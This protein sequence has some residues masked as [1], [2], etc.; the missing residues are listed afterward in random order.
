M[1]TRQ[2][3]PSH[4][5]NRKEKNPCP[6]RVTLGMSASGSAPG[7]FFSEVFRTSRGNGS[8]GVPV[9]PASIHGRTRSIGALISRTWTFL[10][11]FI[12]DVATCLLYTSDAAD[13][14]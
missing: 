4:D 7:G 5:S 13:E 2:R 11:G 12:P 6:R 14:R 1:R 10:I 8:R 9:Q 3:S